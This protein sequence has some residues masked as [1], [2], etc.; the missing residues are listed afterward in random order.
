M[1]TPPIQEVLPSLHLFL[2]NLYKQF[3]QLFGSIGLPRGICP[4]VDDIQLFTHELLEPQPVTL[5]LQPGIFRELITN[6]TI[7]LLF[8]SIGLQSRTHEANAATCASDSGSASE[9][10]TRVS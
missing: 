3:P 4:S 9:P 8:Q 5:Q 10:A 1:V 6:S 7:K 2:P